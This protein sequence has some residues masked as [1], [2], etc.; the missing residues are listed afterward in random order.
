MITREQIAEALD[1]G[2]PFAGQ[3][4]DIMSLI[5]REREQYQALVD[6]VSHA[7]KIQLEPPDV[8]KAMLALAAVFKAHR[9]LMPP[10]PSIPDRL[11][12]LADK[13]Q[14]PVSYGQATV[15]DFEAKLRA[16]ATELR[17]KRYE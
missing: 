17:E 11:D 9:E 14:K 10:P 1:K 15:T 16:I 5:E 8:E 3:I 13:C 2:E 4:D 6:A 7:H 12:A